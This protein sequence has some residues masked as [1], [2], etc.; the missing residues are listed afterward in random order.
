MSKKRFLCLLLTLACLL[1]L[2]T[3]CGRGAGDPNGEEDE[4]ALPEIA[5]TIDLTDTEYV[6][7]APGGSDSDDLTEQDAAMK[8]Y[9]EIHQS[10]RIKLPYYTDKMDKG[11]DPEL[12]RTEILIGQTN[13]TESGKAFADLR[14]NDYRIT[15][16]DGRVLILGGSP[17]ATE[18]AVEHFIEKYLDLSQK[19]ITVYENRNDC[20]RYPYL[21]G[22]L[23]V[24]GTPLKNYTIVY[25]RGAQRND[26]LTY[27]TAVAL[28]DYLLT[29]AG[30]SLR[31]QA[32]T[33]TEREYEILVGKTNR[34]ASK[35]S[36]TTLGQNEFYLHTDGSKLVMLG[37]S[38]LVAGAAGELINHHFA[39]KG[40]NVDI[41][42]TGIPSSPTPKTHTFRKATSALLLIGDG[43]GYNHIDYTVSSHML[44]RFI[45][46]DLPN[47]TT[48]T[49]VSQSVLDGKTQYTDSAAASTALATGYKTYNGYVGIDA[50]KTAQLNLRELA[51]DSGARTAVITT[52]K[53]TGATPSG[54]LCHHT[55]RKDTAVL[56]EQ[57][58]ALVANE[59]IDF[60]HG[61]NAELVTPARE[62]LS[63]ISEGGSSFF[64]LIEEDHIDKKA[65]YANSQG[66]WDS[67][68][69]YNEICAYAICFVMLHPDTALIITA[70]HETGGLVKNADGSYSFEN[71]SY[72][73]SDGDDYYQHTSTQTPVFALGY[74]TEEL[75]SRTLDNTDI[76]KF[77][78]AIYGEPNFG[79]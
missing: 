79:Q 60:A 67:V 11:S 55:S 66:V 7:I 22:N 25:P 71:F 52:D 75:T 29:N 30:I 2:L 19:T 16:A 41:N 54:F 10:T 34:A 76:A 65:H 51:F 13:R 58:D 6:I 59:Q 53:L 27:Y 23:S 73:E 35:E 26:P 28:A 50:S 17:E 5:H 64:A 14:V 77:I 69:R 37:N 8:L 78:A 36:T 45:A 9:T 48:C 21:V 18:A 57:I 62:G 31:V 24:N 46:F 72:T 20:Y 15:Y 39:T 68:V 1:P 42:A 47:Q 12:R 38:Y 56:Q 33:S 61:A 49:T 3:A 40:T 74:G 63:M 4:Q 43:M 32:D 44:D 70:D